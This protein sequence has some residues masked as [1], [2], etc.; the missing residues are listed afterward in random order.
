MMSRFATTI[1]HAYHE[2]HYRTTRSL[3]AVWHKGLVYLRESLA[4]M[5]LS[6]RVER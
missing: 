6:E 3:A 2:S 4:P 1:R 5:S